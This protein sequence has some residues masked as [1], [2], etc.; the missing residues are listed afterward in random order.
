MDIVRGTKT[1]D[2]HE[3]VD[4]TRFERWFDAVLPQLPQGSVTVMD[5]ASYHSQKELPSIV[6][7]EGTVQGV[8]Y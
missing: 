7:S 5:N 4:G 6:A 8:L 3:E 2:Y 1:G